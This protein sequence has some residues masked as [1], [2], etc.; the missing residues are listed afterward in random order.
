LGTPKLPVHSPGG[1]RLSALPHFQYC[2][3]VFT[4]ALP[5]GVGYLDTASG[6]A[7]YYLVFL[8]EYTIVVDV[9]HAGAFARSAAYLAACANRI[10]VRFAL[11][12]AFSAFVRRGIRSMPIGGVYTFVGS[13]QSS[14]ALL[15]VKGK[16]R[17]YMVW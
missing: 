11:R 9:V 16:C 2:L 14:F 15:F 7:P 12:R 5:C 4:S 3:H 13:C 6:D 17:C 8:F 10:R 1:W